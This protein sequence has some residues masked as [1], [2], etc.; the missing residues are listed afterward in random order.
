MGAVS[1]AVASG[2]GGVILFGST[3]PADL[4]SQIAAIEAAVPGRLGL[5]VM[6]DEE[7][8]GVQR[9]ANLVGS[10]PWASYMGA[11][12]T[13]AEITAQVA[14]VARGMAQYGVNMDLAPV[15]DVDGRN[16]PPGPTDPD[17]WRSFS[18]STS[19]VTA[20][21][22]AYMSG[23]EEGGVIPVLKHF[24]GL[25]GASGNTDNGT[26]T[27]L[28]WMTLQTVGLPPFTAAIQDGA[29]AIMVSNAVV[30]GLT[31]L[32][33]SLSTVAITDELVGTLHFDGL[34]LTDLL[35]AG[36]ISDAGFSVTS[37]AV[38]AI[39]TGADMVMYTSASD[40]AA[41]QQFQ[42]IVDA[43][44]AAVGNGSLALGRLVAAA[45]AALT[46]RHLNVCP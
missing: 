3:A 38:Q 1:S 28:P 25:G 33:A 18:G 19:V 17:G 26:A 13:P 46:A 40:A 14:A 20:D 41:L 6:T 15:V 42:A 2:A 24:P 9:M 45:A 30:P 35:S 39:V 36:A 23:L 32:P 8:G 29:P 12:W 10:L 37:A 34:I 7:G 44:V 22:I 31:Q 16:V 43:D 27:T 11:N 21:G 5:L 4:G